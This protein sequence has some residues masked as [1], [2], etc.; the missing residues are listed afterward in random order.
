MNSTRYVLTILFVALSGFVMLSDFSAFSVAIPSLAHQPGITP[1]ALSLIG[2]VSSV[3]FASFLIFGGR[4]IDLYGPVRTCAAGMLLYLIGAVLAASAQGAIM[5]F[6]AR[7]LQGFSFALLGPAGFSIIN[8]GLPEGPIRDRGLGIYAGAQGAAMIAGSVLGGTITTYFGWR[9][10]FLMNLPWVVLT[11]A[12]AW[13]LLRR[14]PERTQAGSM[15]LVGSLLIAAST[16]LLI[17]SLTMAG[18]IGWHSVQ[19]PLTLGLAILGYVI[20]VVYERS[21]EHPLVPPAI[22]R[23]KRM[24][25]N[26]L[27][28]IGIMI[29]AAAM[30]ILPN[31]Y[32]Q[33]VMG[34]SAAKSGFGMLPQ[35][36]TN[37][38]TGG[39]L[40]YA[41]GRFSFRQ[42]MTIAS[43]VY[44]TGLSL[45]LILPILLPHA[46]YALVVGVPLVLS[47]FGGPFGAF[48]ILANCT[49]R[50]P[51]SQRGIVTSVVM[52]S[53]QIGLALGVALVLTIAAS[54]DAL[55]AAPVTTLRYGYL[56]CLGA[57]LL[58]ALCGMGAGKGTHASEQPA[59]VAL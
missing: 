57:A 34:Y 21:L 46:G 35:A 13:I 29:A 55:G 42:N 17:W 48:A 12:L 47:S 18:Q 44:V 4:L 58:G 3:M 5:L 50:S 6:A 41:I 52:S 45:F 15:D 20:F 27:A 22:F 32:M 37:I 33:Q 54:G 53:Q 30:F 19:V 25:A 28:T 59:S 40:A 31:M 49:A 14:E 7:A 9:V 23:N 26:M 51:A 24:I 38:T 39:I 1:E 2:P 8:S 10:I 11:L 36:L 43:V 56:A 16:A